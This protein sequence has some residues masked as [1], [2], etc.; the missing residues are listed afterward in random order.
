MGASKEQFTAERV[1]EDKRT[2]DE[3]V[4]RDTN[5][6]YMRDMLSSGSTSAQPEEPKEEQDV[7]G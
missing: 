6:R 5:I 2:F 7:Q 4:Q 3:Q 1:A